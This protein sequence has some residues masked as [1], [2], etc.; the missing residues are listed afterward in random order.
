MRLLYVDHMFPPP[1]LLLLLQLPIGGRI[2][3]EDALKVVE[4]S[5]FLVLSRKLESGMSIGSDGGA[6]MDGT[7]CDGVGVCVSASKAVTA[8]HN[9]TGLTSG[10]TVKVY[11]PQTRA[12][13]PLTVEV[14]NSD[15]DYAVLATTGVFSKYLPLYNGPSS[16]L[17]G[18]QLA[19]CAFQLGIHEELHEWSS[20]SVGVMPA[21]GVKLS[22]EAHHLLYTSDTWPGDSGGALVLY[23]GELVGLHLAGVNALKEQ[24][25]QK[26][27]LN[28]RVTAV[29]ESLES[30]ARSVASG[31]V[32][33]LA[34]VFAAALDV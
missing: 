34:H 9:L 6:S 17:V 32:A 4:G 21:T 2:I 22:R 23:S 1:A 30:A 24:F 18:K 25:E 31:C 28:E 13:W 27:T 33:L 19:L 15:L 14:I 11:F 20:S 3:S 8:A 16:S 5:L 12:K 26:R 7:A 10:D 29:E